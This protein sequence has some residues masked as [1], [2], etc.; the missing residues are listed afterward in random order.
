MESWGK[1]AGRYAEGEPPMLSKLWSHVGHNVVGY[2]AFFFALT[3][4]AY[5]AGPLKAG[6]SASGDLTG[7]YPNPQIATGA[8]GTGEG[9]R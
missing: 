5:A 6:D 4:V 3:G 8:V 9:R 2:L 7:T 1:G